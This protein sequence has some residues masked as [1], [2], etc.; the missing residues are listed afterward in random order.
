MPTKK[1]QIARLI[2]EMTYPEVTS[3][4]EDFVEMQKSAKTLEDDA[5]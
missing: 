4:A 1:Q 3:L 5:A 2:S